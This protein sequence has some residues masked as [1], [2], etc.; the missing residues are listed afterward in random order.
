[1]YSYRILNSLVISF[2][3]ISCASTQFDRTKVPE[4]ESNVPATTS[5]IR[6]L[7]HKKI[8]SEQGPRDLHISGQLFTKGIEASNVNI[9]PCSACLVELRA[10]QDTSVVVRIT[11]E[12]DG[13]FSFHGKN[14]TFSLLSNNPGLNKILI[15]RVNFDTAGLT[16]IRIVNA[17]G[18]RSENFFVTQT[19][20]NYSWTNR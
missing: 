19:G 6:E 5:E 10:L 8:R 15:D 13:Y 17:I 16:T 2:T 12:N 14:Y 11:T 7:K 9:K 18:N 20:K 1:M 3:G 4:V